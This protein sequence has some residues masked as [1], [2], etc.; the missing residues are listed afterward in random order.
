MNPDKVLLLG[1]GHPYR[2]DDGFGPRAIRSLQEKYGDRYDYR[3]HSGDP[4]DLLD[5]WD[6]RTLVILDAMRCP[7]PKPGTLHEF[8]VPSHGILPRQSAVSSHALSLAEALELGRILQR[9]PRECI[10]LGV[11]GENFAPG[12]DLSPSV[13]AALDRVLLLVPR[14]MK[15]D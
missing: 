12:E 15:G 14:L 11:E 4:A 5:I 6:H 10:I 8:H 2:S 1:L 9:M 7:H 13:A 3:L